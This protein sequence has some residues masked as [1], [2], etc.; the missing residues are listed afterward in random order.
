MITIMMMI[1]C[2]MYV[3]VRVSVPMC[4]STMPV[5]ARGEHQVSRD[6]RKGSWNALLIVVLRTGLTQVLWKKKVVLGTTEPVLQTE[7]LIPRSLVQY[8]FFY[9]L[10]FCVVPKKNH[11]Q[12]ENHIDL[13]LYYLL[14][15]SVLHLHL[16]MCPIFR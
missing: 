8:F 16:G 13:I 6:W 1:V 3:C 11:S 10:C 4:T 14:E 5:E 7:G 2:C 15:I 12:I 9:W